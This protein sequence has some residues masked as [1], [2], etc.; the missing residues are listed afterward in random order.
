MSILIQNGVLVLPSGPVKAD[1]R[2]E[3]DKIAEIGPVLPVGGSRV[4]DASGR[5]VFPGFIDTHTHF[6]MNKGLPNETADDFITGTRAAVVGGTTCILDFATQ[7]RGHTLAD[8]LRIWHERADGR[9]SCHYGFHMAVTDWNEHTRAELRD[10]TAAGVTSYKVYMAYEALRLNDGPVYE[11]LKAVGEE[12]G[13]VGCHCENGDLVNEGIA[14]QRAMGRLSPAA[15]PG[16][17]PPVVEAE[18]VDRFL[19][20]AE[21]AGAPVNI[22]HLSTLRGLEIVRAARARGQ[23][24][25]VESCPQY[26]LLDENKYALPGFESAKFVLSPPLRAVENCAALW[27]AVRSGEVDTLGTDHCSFHFM[28]PKQLGRDDFSKIP[29]GIPGVEHRPALLWTYGVKEGRI[30]ETDMARLMAENPAKLF[31]MYPQKGVLAEG[32]DADIV[33]FD[34]NYTGSITAAT[35]TQN[36]DYTPYEGFVL[37]GR[38]DTVLLSGE[39]VTEGGKLVAEN[40]GRYVSR[41]PSQLWR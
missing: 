38:A 26:L 32:S 39:V 10:M 8:G 4:L 30:T 15:H 35:Q 31:G 19:A 36:V 28:G 33:I 41:G 1:L 9:S 37:K 6:E 3:G 16:S 12:G 17:R 22:V 13:I 27:E 18:A 40:R 25:Y 34:T 23:R 21:T 11:I 5:L 24:L 2:V 29:N 7:D 20:I 14:A